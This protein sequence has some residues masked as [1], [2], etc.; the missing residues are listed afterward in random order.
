MRTLPFIS[1]VILLLPSATLAQQAEQN[2]FAID[3]EMVF[4]PGGEFKMGD[5]FFEVN[6]D[7][8]PVH[9]VTVDDFYIGKYPVTFEQY[10]A[11]ANAYGLPLPEG[12]GRGRGSRAVINVDWDDAL[13]FCESLGYRLP[14]EQEWE[15]AA[16][17]GGGIE[18]F[19]GTNDRTSLEDFAHFQFNSRPVSQ[20]VGTKKPNGLGI[21]DMSGNVFEWIGEWY[22]M[23]RTDPRRI[24]L[25]P[26]DERDMRVIRGGS[27]M[28]PPFTIRTYWRAYTFRGSRSGEIGLRCA[29]DYES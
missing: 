25:Y 3:Y 18:L 26:I 4:V 2:E 17:S 8:L 19:S 11:F 22:N 15:Y 7:A 9:L 21:Y 20:P 6:Q 16:R 10:D 27:I 28:Q 29:A 24:T 23:Y 1:L 14:T 5:L 12:N 13:A